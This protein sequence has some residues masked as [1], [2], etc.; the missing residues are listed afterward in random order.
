[1]IRAPSCT[2]GKNVRRINQ[3]K[4]NACHGA[5]VAISEK[6]LLSKAG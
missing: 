4:L 2:D 6:N 3:T 5:A 1:M